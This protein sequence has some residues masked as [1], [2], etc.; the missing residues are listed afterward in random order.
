M[1]AV[2]KMQWV[3]PHS[4]ARLD[5]RAYNGGFGLYRLS[6]SGELEALQ[7]HFL[8]FK[9]L[10]STLQMHFT[11]RNTAREAIVQKLNIQFIGVA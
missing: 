1:N 9:A 4:L 10:Q 7:M 3:A 5:S 8:Y 2:V 11:F 6:G